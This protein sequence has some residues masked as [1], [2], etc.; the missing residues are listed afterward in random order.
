MSAFEKD[1]GGAGGDRSGEGSP[2]SASHRCRLVSVDHP[3]SLRKVAS[4]R[5]HL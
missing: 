4:G 3:S 2:G 5:A 1:A